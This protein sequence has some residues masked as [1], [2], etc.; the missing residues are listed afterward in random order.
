MFRLP[1][2]L[3]SSE[4]CWLWWPYITSSR[5]KAKRLHI[6]KKQACLLL[7]IVLPLMHISVPQSLPSSLCRKCFVQSISMAGLHSWKCHLLC[8]V[9]IGSL[10]HLLKFVKFPSNIFVSLLEKQ[11]V[12]AH[13]KTCWFNEELMFACESIFQRN[14]PLYI[15]IK[16]GSLYISFKQDKQS[17]LSIFHIICP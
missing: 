12:Q 16:A 3:S 13:L 5:Q 14:L 10:F 9:V 1:L 6:K 4:I 17:R 2:L 15:W 8:L 11:L 7:G